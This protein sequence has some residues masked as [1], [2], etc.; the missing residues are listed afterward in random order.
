MT[1]YELWKLYMKGN[2]APRQFMDAGWIFMIAAALER[3]VWLNSSIK[4]FPNHY[5]LMCGQPGAGKSIVTGPV[6]DILN[7]LTGP[8][9]SETVPVY[10]LKRGPDSS[11]FEKIADIIAKSTTGG[12][13]YTD[14]KGTKRP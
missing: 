13:H 8:G 4:V 7:S 5:I 14:E 1:N 3:R 2:H 12:M 10:V 9:H 6:N 11:S